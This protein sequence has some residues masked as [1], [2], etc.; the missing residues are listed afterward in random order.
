MKILYDGWPL[1]YRPHSPAALHLMTLLERQPPG[2]QALVALPGGPPAWLPQG[3]FPRVRPTPDT[4]WKRLFWEHCLLPA[5][6]RQMQADLVHL[7]TPGPALF[8]PARC[9]ISPTG[10]WDGVGKAAWWAPPASGEPGG[11][12]R[13][14]FAERLSRSLDQGG[15]ARLRGIFWPA[16]LPPPGGAQAAP[17]FRLPPAVHPGFAPVGVPGDAGVGGPQRP[18]GVPGDAGVGDTAQTL[19]A[20]GL[21]DAYVLYHGPLSPPALE[22]LLNA[23]RWAAAAIGQAFPLVLLG[24][25]RPA[26][27]RLPGAAQENTLRFLPQVPFPWLVE[28]YR[29]CAALLHVG[30]ISPWGDPI[31]HALA[32]GRPV[33]AEENALVDALTGP[34]AYLAPAS[35]DRTLG[36]AVITLV[37]EEEVAMRLSL[38]A[39]QRAHAWQREA[40]SQALLEAYQAILNLS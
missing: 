21:P 31:R 27:D 1:I 22:R 5:L 11:A 6:A 3:V 19:S 25:D 14:A 37:V 17:L 35:D 16:D 29:G 24:A 33:A 12:R 15:A 26:G 20:L 2:V 32:C 13:P 34:A 4:P 36:A 18:F 10:F 8:C 40:F 7:T 30:P 39:R 28:I 23:W 38:A 9:A